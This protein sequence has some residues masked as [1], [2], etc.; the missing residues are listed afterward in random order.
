MRET[1]RSFRLGPSGKE[2]GEVAAVSWGDPDRPPDVLWAHAN[3]FNAVTYR[4]IL[5]P[6][7]DA[8]L[9][10][11]AVDLRG[12]GR[13]TLPAHPS[14]RRDWSEFRDDLAAVLDALDAPP[15]VMAGH[16]F[17]ATSS[18]LAAVSRPTRVK[19]LAL[20]DPVMMATPFPL[21]KGVPSPATT[22]WRRTPIVRGAQKRR[23]VFDSRARAFA[24]YKGRG[25]F[26]TWPDEVLADYLEDGLRER[27]DGRVELSC[28]PAWEASNFSAQGSDAWRAVRQV[29]CPIRVL[30]AE[31]AST[32][33]V[34]PGW[35]AR[36]QAPVRIELVPRTTHFL[37]MERPERVREVLVESVGP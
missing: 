1:R 15:L 33:R 2:G 28:A 7:A 32:C 36:A 35:A 9:T 5:G 11:L 17:G 23:A 30:R 27:A 14:L 25:A 20:F 8:G 31:Y 24:A 13:T 29:R 34:G 19:A 12:H 10:V 6:L 4:S 3:G 37:P 22:F 21:F 26:R 18:L 16:S